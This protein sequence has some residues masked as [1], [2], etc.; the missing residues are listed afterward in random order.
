MSPLLFYFFFVLLPVSWIFTLIFIFFL[1]LTLNLICSSFSSF[2]KQKLCV[3]IC[4]FV[5]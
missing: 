3:L 5:S 2:L 4:C 1:L